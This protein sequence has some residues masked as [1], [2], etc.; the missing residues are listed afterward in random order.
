MIWKPPARSS[1]ATCRVPTA[2]M[3]TFRRNSRSLLRVPDLLCVRTGIRI[4]SRAK[5]GLKVAMSHAVNNEE[6]AWDRGL[7]DDDLVAFIRCS[8][9]PDGRWVA[10][11]RVTLFRVRDM[12]TT[13]EAAGLTRMK[14]AS[15]GSE[16]QLVWPATIPQQ[17]GRVSAVTDDA[18]ETVQSSGRRQ[19]YRLRAERGRGTSAVSYQLH[20]YVTTGDGFGGGDTI[21]AAVMPE[22]VST[23]CRDT[24]QYDFVRD[25]RSESRETVYAAAKALGFLPQLADTSKSELQR[26]ARNHGDALVRLESAAALARLGVPEGWAAIEET[27]GRAEEIPLRMEAVLVVGELAGD[28]ALRLLIGVA[29]NRSNPSELRAAAV[30][31]MSNSAPSLSATPLLQLLAD[32]DELVAVHALVSAS[33]IMDAGGLAFALSHVGKDARVS[34]GVARAVLC[35]SIDPVPATVAAL[36]KATGE[37]RSWLL[38]L[39]AMLGRARC[40]GYLATDAPEIMQ[41]LEFFWARHV[42]NWTN[43]L[44]VAD[45]IDFQL[46][47]ILE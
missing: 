29:E 46:A 39:L 26:V 47:Q 27:L 36:R 9:T 31:G 16:I 44:D 37:A 8:E 30:W 11:D 1:R 19:R 2:P 33:Q 21:I 4:E 32:E 42:E 35:G 6:R 24:G 20:S 22:C 17:A 14:A 28:D 18:I 34:A 12:R 40:E 45:Q 38:Y 7:R 41:E 13:V 43:R 10:S 25:L 23:V 3:V 5:S 15:E